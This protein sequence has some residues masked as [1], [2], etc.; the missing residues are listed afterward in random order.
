MKIDTCFIMVMENNEEKTNNILNCVKNIG[1]KNLYLNKVNKSDF[2]LNSLVNSSIV[3]TNNNNI[4][5][6]NLNKL[7]KNINTNNYMEES[8][9]YEYY[10]QTQIW[11]S[12]LNENHSKGDN[13][14]IIDNRIKIKNKETF[15]EDFKE[16]LEYIPELFGSV[17]LCSCNNFRGHLGKCNEFLKYTNKTYNS[18]YG[19]IISRHWI[20]NL[21]NLAFPMKVSL[22]TLIQDIGMLKKKGYILKYPLLEVNEI[23]EEHIP[24][25]ISLPVQSYNNPFSKVYIVA[26]KKER[27]NNIKHLSYL[28]RIFYRLTKKNIIIVDS[29]YDAA[30]QAKLDDNRS[31]VINS[32]SNIDNI[33][34][35]IKTIKY[36]SIDIPKCCFFIG[37]LKKSINNPF[38]CT[39]HLQFIHP[40]MPKIENFFITKEGANLYCNIHDN[41]IIKN[42]NIILSRERVGFAHIT[43]SFD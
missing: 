14:L 36:C 16:M 34:D 24:Q 42:I 39:K 3:Q 33:P 19:Y 5:N 43:N 26:N 17:G 28:Y 30:T 20:P 29:Y 22:N 38:N 13:I 35:L 23:I 21:L 8:E 41:G 12:L 37:L 1:I 6:N 4:S 31:L 32:T 10:V 40:S 27:L 18:S 7:V 25:T 11:K 15:A 9:I 2:N